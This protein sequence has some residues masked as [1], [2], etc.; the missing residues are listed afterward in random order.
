M[1]IYT[2]W[3]TW[4]QARADLVGLP[5]DLDALEKAAVAAQRWHGDQQRPTGVPYVE[6]L[7]EAL[8]VLV[9]GAGVTGP[10]ILAA[11]LLHD[12]V[13][14]TSATTAD[15]EA[16]FGPVVAELVDWVTK[17]PAGGQ[18]RQAKRAAKSAYLRRLGE[19]PPEAVTVKL[20]DRASNVQRLDQMPPDFQRRY[21][22]E[23]VT[24]ILP[25]AASDPF[26]SRWYAEWR[27]QFAH[28][29]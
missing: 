16:E 9:R 8:E 7:L 24:Y 11:V 1:E 21:Y 23:T 15:V 10:E 3:R 26:F 29:R 25:L 6:H 22:A 14:D 17:P 18:G 12:V 19:A 4:D 5:V 27:E 2:S 13:E 20:A 28:L